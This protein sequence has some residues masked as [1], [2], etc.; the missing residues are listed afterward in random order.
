MNWKTEAIEKLRQYNA[1]K[2]ALTNIPEE[3]SR[4]EQSSCA[5]RSARTDGTPVKGGT[6]RREDALI[7]NLVYRQEL[8][9]ALE[10]AKSW[11]SLVSS[12]LGVLKPDEKLILTRLYIYPEKNN[13]DRLCEELFI[14]QSSVYRRRDAALRKFTT[15]LYGIAET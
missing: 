10:N 12:A 11:V 8:T 14:E 2:T 7:D 6:N 1:M 13:V 9:W 15:A 3:L 4:L 5:I